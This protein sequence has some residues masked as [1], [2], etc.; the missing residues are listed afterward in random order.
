MASKWL[1]VSDNNTGSRV[2]MDSRKKRVSQILKT[3]YK[4]AGV[5]PTISSVSKKTLKRK[6]DDTCNCSTSSKNLLKNYSNFMKSGLPQHIMFCEDGQWNDFSQDVIDS[7]KEHFLAKTTAFE[8]KFNGRHLMLDVLHMNK[9]D[10]KTGSRKPIAWIDEKGSSFF[11]EL[12]SGCHEIQKDIE[13]DP[14]IKL[15]VEIELNENNNLDECIEESNVKRVKIDQEGQT[16]YHGQN[17]DAEIE[18]KAD[19]SVEKIQID[20]ETVRNMFMNSVSQSQTNKVDII[21]VKKYSGEIM[22]SKLDLFHAQGEI[23]KK[24]R[25]NANV[26]YGWFASPVGS[27]GVNGLGHDG[28]KLGRY[29]YGVHLTAFHSAHNSGIV[30]DVDEKGVRCMILCRVILGNTEVILPGSKQFFPSKECFDSG[31]DNLENPNHYVVWNMN[32]NTHIYPEYVVSFKMSTSAQGNLNIEQSR[33]DLSKVTTQDPHALNL[34]K[35]EMQFQSG[36]A[37]VSSEKVP[38]IGS[39]SSRAPNSPWM[40][41]SKLFEAISDK[42]DP[43]NMKQVHI[44]YESLR[45]KKTTREDPRLNSFS[46]SY[47]TR[48][49]VKTKEVNK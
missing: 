46:Y 15:H 29:G 22:E 27:T 13:I 47:R 36:K 38:S 34:D 10:L 3:S 35:N 26:Q 44:L 5:K 37:S 40:P 33:V 1:K 30:C 45:G 48:I 49:L 9:L 14:E 28:L 24:L 31:V 18:S 11:P 23:T 6:R 16:N 4:A 32:M 7:V 8:V 42:V 2:I 19:Q 43:D 21:E 12:C 41:F 25:G 20:E 17:I 39:S